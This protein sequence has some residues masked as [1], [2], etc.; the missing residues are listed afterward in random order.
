MYGA[1]NADQTHHLGPK[2][3]TW[4]GWSRSC[5]SPQTCMKLKDVTITLLTHKPFYRL[6]A[7]ST[8]DGRKMSQVPMKCGGSLLGSHSTTSTLS[9]DWSN[10]IGNTSHTSW[11]VFIDHTLAQHKN[12]CTVPGNCIGFGSIHRHFCFDNHRQNLVG[13]CFLLSSSSSSSPMLQSSRKFFL[14]KMVSV[15]F[16]KKTVS[17]LGNDPK[18]MPRNHNSLLL[19]I[20]SC[21]NSV[22]G[23]LL[24]TT[25][26]SWTV[27]VTLTWGWMGKVPTNTNIR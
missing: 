18:K 9:Q 19:F 26:R 22:A 8:S 20:V 10:T 17:L 24:R 23:N 5:I 1:M 3:E 13:Q 14:H 6:E 11:L 4:R 21:G 25:L 2:I 7:R 16:W 27:V 12:T 15:S